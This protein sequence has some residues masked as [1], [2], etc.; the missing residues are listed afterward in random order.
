MR[1]EQQRAGET[2]DRAPPP[3]RRRRRGFCSTSHSEKKSIRILRYRGRG[4]VTES[5]HEMGGSLICHRRKRKKYSA[6]Y[7]RRVLQSNHY[8]DVVPGKKNPATSFRRSCIF[9]CCL[10]KEK[11]WRR[12]DGGGGGG[13]GGKG[14]LRRD[15]IL[16]AKTTSPFSRLFAGTSLFSS[17]FCSFYSPSSCT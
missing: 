7:S 6:S 5:R 14:D 2:G 11:R 12:D 10:M 13:G 9:F 1:G 16:F 15:V 3:G 17:F 4:N 8:D